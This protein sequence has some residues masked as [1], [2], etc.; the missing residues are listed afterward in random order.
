MA[1][2]IWRVDLG[3]LLLDPRLPLPAFPVGG[4]DFG[5]ELAG[6]LRD[7]FGCQQPVLEHRAA[8][9]AAPHQT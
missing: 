5:D 4:V 9:Q 8:A 1:L 6:E 2:R 7:E 3:P